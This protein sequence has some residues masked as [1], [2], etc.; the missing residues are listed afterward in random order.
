MSFSF[1]AARNYAP[2]LCRL[3]LAAAFVPIGWNKM[4]GG[5]RVYQGEDAR[6]LRALGVAGTGEADAASAAAWNGPDVLAT[7]Q[8]GVRTGNLVERRPLQPKREEPPASQA[9]DPAS[10]PPVGGT[11]TGPVPGGADLS[12]APPTIVDPPRRDP[13]AGGDEPSADATD[14]VMAKPIYQDAVRLT[15]AG[16]GPPRAP[17]WLPV[18]AARVTAFFQLVGAGLLVIGLL[19]RV[20]ATG[21]SVF[22]AMGFYLTSWTALQH[23]GLTPLPQAEFEALFSHVCLFVMA[24]SVALTGAGGL[25]LD[26]VFFRPDDFDLE[27]DQLMGLS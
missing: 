7:Y 13:F 23:Y 14:A 25:S 26:G 1:T 20:W 24:L 12:G 6:I 2:L 15:A 5:E 27:D 19:A 11:T 17:A 3:V 18:W 9:G 8:Q 21:L 4:L 16:L 10:A 22:I